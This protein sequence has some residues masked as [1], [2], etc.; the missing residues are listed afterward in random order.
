M[1]SSSAHDGYSSGIIVFKQ[2]QFLYFGH[3]NNFKNEKWKT[4]LKGMIE[5]NSA[6]VAEFLCRVQVVMVKKVLDV[7]HCGHVRLN[8]CFR[9]VASSSQTGWEFY[10][11]E[12]ETVVQE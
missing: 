10:C 9:C 5:N 12:S 1:Y 3:V 2:F 11:W 6:D 8:F 7:L 4:L